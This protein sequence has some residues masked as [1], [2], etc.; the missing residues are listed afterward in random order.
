MRRR[1]LIVALGLTLTAASWL[2]AQTMNAWH[3]DRELRLA[4][5][6][7]AARRLSEA[8]QRLA[9]L[10]RRWPERGDVEYWLGVCAMGQTDPDAAMAAWQRVPED[11]REAPL[12]EL[13]LGRVA[14]EGCHYILA[15]ASLQ[16]ASRRNAEVGAEARRMLG[17]LYW[18][19][20]RHDEYQALLRIEASE[21]ADPSRVLR[22][23]W[24]LDN[25]PFPLETMTRT[26]DQAD[27]L[28]PAD[29]RVWLARAS[30]A[31]RGGRLDEADG[32]LARCEQAR[33]DDP[34]IWNAR[35]DWA[36]AAGRPTELLRAAAHLPAS[37]FSR[38]RLLAITAWLA[39]ARGERT[40]E[41]AA[42]QELLRLDPASFPAIERLAGLAA[43]QGDA[44][45]V[46]EL[47]HRKAELEVARERYRSLVNQPDPAA[48]AALL[49]H[50]AAALDRR[51]DARAWWKLAAQRDPAYQDEARLAIARLG[52][53]PQPEAAASGMLADLL[54]P[55]A[56][57]G[58][59]AVPA[60]RAGAA[61]AFF[62]DDAL[63]AGL[64][65]QF[66][67]GRS[68]NRQLPETMSGGM[69]VLD[70]DG[71]G[72]LDVYCVQ[73]GRFP[74]P[75]G[76]QPSGDRLFR[77]L[78]GGRFVDATVSS[79]LAGFAGGY[80][81]GVAVGDYDNDGRPDLFVTRWGAYALYHNLGAG[82][83]EDCTARAGL[84][85]NRDWPTSAAWA[86]LDGDGDLD[87]YVCHYLTW[88]A[89]NPEICRDPQSQNPTYCDPRYYN[90]LPD[91]VFRNDG[92]RFV[93]VTRE[94][95]IVDTQGRGLGVL[96]ADLNGDGR[97]DL[98][99]TN[100]TTANY[101]FENQGGFRFVEKGMD[102]GLATSASGGYLA[103]MG[104]ACGDFDGDGRPDVAVT[105]FYGEST[106]LY[107]NHGEGLFSDGSAAAGLESA[108]RAMLGFGLAAVDVNND[109][110]LDLAQANGHVGDFRP[111]V[112]YAMPSQLF[113]GD[114]SSRF[115][116]VSDRAGPVWT[117]P[118]LGRGLTAGD[119]DNDGRIDLLMV[120]ENEP[121]LFL[122]NQSAASGHF[123][124][125]RLEG[126]ASS[127]DAVGARVAVTASGVTRVAPRFGGGSYMSAL[128]QRLHFGLD[129]ARKVDR[130]E[131][132]W[133]SGKHD[134][135]DD[136]AADQGYR[137]REGDPA[138]QPLPGF[139][140]RSH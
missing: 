88:N 20:G 34:V 79:G 109:G 3:L 39:A 78:G 27:R 135:Y 94:A 22:K 24:D 86:D 125:L 11:C 38:P 120:V 12:A 92:G 87:L 122:H 44:P 107:H 134:S 140:A 15:E 106:T 118:R 96:A 58:G 62:R 10:A 30:L 54:G 29:D 18:M 75:S 31:T 126:T 77:N 102:Y 105:N 119:L 32:W 89:Q 43:E 130:I 121:T 93:D 67:N 127:R 72:W 19:T 65:F 45:Q 16:R 123:L 117:V 48:S 82:R 7:F 26:L 91:H 47:R 98:L 8:R 64:H 97:T 53:R 128:D 14:I 17:W 81:F 116:D 115:S 129:Q 138:P 55:R 36:M 113:L 100:D 104:I 60:A 35:L 90:A 68:D 51:F 83:F 4:E 110:K 5:H 56:P 74:P 69:G 46:A 40:A 76:S 84:G 33:P 1:L 70:F 85:G 63:P 2:G 13:A 50:A 133:P 132:F 73:G 114:G 28:A 9:R 108:T 42:L 23:L 21:L 41:Q 95:G 103:G 131:V 59:P 139:G 124:T 57:G 101:V 71:D 37:S 52:D 136:L 6:D 49:A 25:E 80:G 99:V 112:P 61:M 111:A 137:L 66:H